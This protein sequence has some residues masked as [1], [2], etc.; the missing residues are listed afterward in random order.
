MF[1]INLIRENPDLVRKN[2]EKRKNP[3]FIA[4]L[5]TLIK[6]DSEWRNH[7]KEVDGLKHERNKISE[8]INQFKKQGK[9][10]SELLKK[11]M[12]TPEMIRK[13]EEKQE[14][15]W[16][17][18]KELL[19][20][21][22]NMMHESVPYGKDDTENV[23]I[24]KWGKTE[25]KGFDLKTHSEIAESLG[26]ADFDRSKKVSGAGFYYLKNELALLNQAL[27]RFAVDTLVKKGY[28]YV[29]PPLMMRR[30]AYEGVVS[31]ED[32]ENIMYKIEGD[33]FYLIATAEHPL[34]A[35]LK[36]E[37]ITEEQ[38]PIKLV[39]YSMCFRKEIGTH[40][41]DEKGFFRTHQ[42]NKVEQF[43][44]CKPEQSWKLHE[45]LQKNCEEIFTALGLP[46]RTVNI[47]T[48]DLGIIAAKKY[49]LEVW[50]PRQEK[51]R[52]IGSNSNC[53][54]YQARRLNIKFV[55]KHGNRRFLHTLNNTAIAT[56]R[57]MVAILENYQ[58]QDGTIT[59][60]K[61]LIPYM[62]GIKIIGKKKR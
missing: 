20:K 57:A 23:E 1:D 33:D 17:K 9:D 61:A 55:D 44:F 40:S 34:G 10:V 42:F 12:E 27:I 36:D 39:G 2:L 6:N 35:M 45:E 58:N 18:Q 30:E 50:L 5:E 16:K 52:E 53:T 14:E 49:D 24:R 4:M 48:G 7:K 26:I 59:V 28:S 15:L 62:N 43:I 51:Y 47:C 32:F 60:P 3:E 29:E 38:L 31:L 8:Q 19:M 25:K 37:T 13:V 46:W 21:L 56:S 22:P 54:D 41:V 11:A